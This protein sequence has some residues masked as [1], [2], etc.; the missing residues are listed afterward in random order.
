[1]NLYL[2]M[3]DEFFL[4]FVSQVEKEKT[5]LVVNNSIQKKIKNKEYYIF[6]EN[7]FFNLEY[8]ESKTQKLDIYLSEAE[9]LSY[10]DVESMFY[11]IIDRLSYISISN[12]I[13]RD[14]FLL[15][16]LFWNNFLIVNKIKKIFINNSPHFGWDNIVYEIAKKN[17]IKVSYIERTFIKN[18][19]ILN[20]DYKKMYKVPS[21]YLE[22]NNLSELKKYPIIDKL[23]EES[24]W[25]KASKDI[26][27]RVI[28][29]KK[30]FIKNIVL[31]ILRNINLYILFS[32]NPP[33]AIYLNP[34]LRNK[35]FYLVF[36]NFLETNKTEKLKQYYESL[37]VHYES[38]KKYIYFAL[39]FQPERT[40]M[41]LGGVF[42]NQLY[43]LKI[44]SESMPDD[45]IIYVKEH[46]RQFDKTMLLLKHK[47]YRSIN[48]Y[49]SLKKI[50]KV[51]IL[52]IEENNN[53][54]IKNANLTA[55]I[56]GSTVWEG[57]LQGVPGLVFGNPWYS[58][59]NSCFIIKSSSDIINI[60]NKYK[61]LSSER[62]LT[63][64]YKFII[65]MEKDFI[66]SS[67]SYGYAQKSDIKIDEQ[68]NNLVNAYL[69]EN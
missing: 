50:S 51:Q 59:C 37:C 20:H 15:N 10:S 60:F 34:S 28:N 57:L 56:S 21:D 17:N 7:D 62:V 3:N 64:L 39:H 23:Y 47:H 49:D 35:P 58:P 54:L 40:T 12:Q 25:S 42:A 38:K 24:V 29:K 65:F 69:K 53:T 32:K 26:N 45:W 4:E 11:Q 66:I 18:S 19:V 2:N 6:L 5:F 52:S 1:M 67:N 27:S 55:S 14:I 33:S 30:S 44:L 41:P 16:L 68:L 48:F 43:A 9:I 31:F 22:N 63:D 13:Q 36:K 46:P 61:L 8:L